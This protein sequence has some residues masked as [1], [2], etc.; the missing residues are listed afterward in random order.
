MWAKAEVEHRTVISNSTPGVGFAFRPDS[1][2][3]PARLHTKG[4][5]GASLTGA[6]V[7]DSHAGWL[8]LYSDAKLAAGT[9]GGA[10]GHFGDSVTIS[11]EGG[12][13]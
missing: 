11:H 4:A 6:T 1:I 7:T 8:S 2:P 13:L 12:T 5:A 10:C 9:C 3:G